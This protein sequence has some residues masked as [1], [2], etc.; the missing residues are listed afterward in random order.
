MN[1]TFRRD[2]T[3]ET[4]RR[5]DKN[6]KALGIFLAAIL[7][8]MV[9]VAMAPSVAAQPITVDGDAS[10]WIGLAGVKSVTDPGHDLIV[11]SPN[12][13]NYT[14]D[15]DS[16]YDLVEFSAYYDVSTDTLCFMFNTSGV[17]GDTDG[18]GDPSNCT[19]CTG[20]CRRADVDFPGVPGSDNYKVN[21]DTNG[22]SIRDFRVVYSG[23]TVKVWNYD[24][25]IEHTANF[26]TQGSI[27]V[28]PWTDAVLEMCI[29]PA[30]NLSNFGFCKNFRVT[31]ARLGS[32]ADYI[33]EDSVGGFDM[34]AAP[35][36]IPVGENKC[37]CNNTTFDGSASYDPDGNITNWTWDFD[38]GNFGYGEIVEH[39]YANPGTYTA[40][41]TVTDDYGFVCSDSVVIRIALCTYRK[42]PI[43]TLPG[44]IALLGLLSVFAV[45]SIKRRS[46]DN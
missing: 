37:F 21:L 33:A 19:N 5:I 3:S 38:D 7:L 34:N 18:D 13:T 12:C 23:N 40:T 20:D 14:I 39:H 22:D 6:R 1:N 29:S 25:S 32:G 42:T 11:Q 46:K 2:F 44:I 24:E 35:V 41:L 26:T 31:G 17:P 8:T 45:T 27:G 9:F 10:D 16:G 43:L 30:H 4:K 36:C 15:W 28:S